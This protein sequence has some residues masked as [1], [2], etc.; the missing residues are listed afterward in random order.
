V[1]TILLIGI[2][3]EGELCMKFVA[4]FF[5]SGSTCI[6]FCNTLDHKYTPPKYDLIPN[7]AST[8]QWGQAAGIL[9]LS[10]QGAAADG[11]QSIARIY[12]MRSLI[13][14][15]LLPFT[16]SGIPNETELTAFNTCLREVNESMKIISTG[17]GYTLIC[18]AV[19]PLAQIV[20]AVV[21]STADLLLSNQLE[22]LK[23]C[24]ECG[25]LFYDTSRNQS[26]RWC[27]MNSCGN[28]AKARRHYE[29]VR[30]KRI[31]TA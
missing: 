25:W 2:H 15:L 14:S 16:C 9:P 29:R 20:C 1:N 7:Y 31:A 23:Q 27:D 26:R 12:D 22:Q 4:P 6:D 19:D 8:L 18:S 24:G 11:Q 5:L 21:R 28:R 3:I 10:F 17:G 13:S 30:Q